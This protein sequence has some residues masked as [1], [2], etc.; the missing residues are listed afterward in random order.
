MELLSGLKTSVN[1]PLGE[2]TINP[3]PDVRL[4]VERESVSVREVPAEAFTILSTGLYEPATPEGLSGF[5]TKAL[6][7]SWLG[8]DPVVVLPEEL[9]PQ[10]IRARLPTTRIARQ[11]RVL[12]KP[13]TPEEHEGQRFGCEKRDYS[14]AWVMKFCTTPRKHTGAMVHEAGSILYSQL[15]CLPTCLPA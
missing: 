4:T 8:R 14:R 2:S 10:E 3:G 15:P 6:E 5:E 1:S 11:N 7:A 12:F 13:G 9:L